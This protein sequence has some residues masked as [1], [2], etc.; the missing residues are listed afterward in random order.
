M[1]PEIVVGETDIDG[2]ADLYSLACVAYWALTGQL[3]FLA[4]TPEQMLLHHARTAPSP[5]SQVSELPIPP[6]IDEIVLRCLAKDPADRPASALDLAADLA[7][8]AFD[9]PWTQDR[10]RAWW[11]LHVPGDRMAGRG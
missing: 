5:P 1:A 3:V 11:E 10:A 9:H 7:G 2:R 8:V 6:A 4:K